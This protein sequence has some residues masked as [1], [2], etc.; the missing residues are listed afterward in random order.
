MTEFPMP[1]HTPVLIIGAGP[2]GLSTAIECV[3]RGLPV[4]IVDQDAEATRES[5]AVAVNPRT[6]DL[7]EPSGAAERL[8]AAGVRLRGFRIVSEGVTRAVADASRLPH[9]FNFILALV[10][11]ETEAIL[12]QVLA[13]KG[14]PVERGVT[15]VDVAS[16]DSGAEA[17]LDGPSG[18]ERVACDWLVG[19]DGAH[20]IV[21]KALGIDFPGEPYPFQWSLADVDLSG[22]VEEDR[23]E[24]RLEVGAPIL[25][26]IPIG[27]GRHRLISNAPD[28]LERLPAAW[29]AGAVHWRSD[30]RVSHRQVERL[31]QGRAW[32]VGDAAHIHSP[33]GGRGMN[34]GI[35]D[36]VTL[37]ERIAAGDLGDWPAER[38]AK[39]ARVIRES[40]R[41][42][43]LATADGPLMRRVMPRLVGALLRVPALHDRFIKAMAG[44]S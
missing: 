13:E 27:P 26:R 21:R 20:S 9:P 36:G 38:R 32:L 29:S 37:A 25:F 3:R 16:R 17:T 15:A 6:L 19:A 33:A 14:V 4:R 8:V 23:A 34:L 1:F 10:Q 31:G 30:F 44:L 7:L 24:L 18:R 40:D 5:R 22:D 41:M 42:Q 39:A 2:V 12:A 35:E 11:N 43:R 28:L